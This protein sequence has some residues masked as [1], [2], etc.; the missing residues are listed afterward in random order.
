M[1]SHIDILLEETKMCMCEVE[2]KASE[3]FGVQIIFES[4]GNLYIYSKDKPDILCE[5]EFKEFLKTC[6]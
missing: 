3:F 2:K 4:D 6:I 1:K 5:N